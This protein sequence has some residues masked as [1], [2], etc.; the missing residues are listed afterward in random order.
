MLSK[1]TVLTRSQRQV[2]KY[3]SETATNGAK[4]VLGVIDGLSQGKGLASYPVIKPK[5]KIIKPIKPQ[6]GELTGDALDN[7]CG[8]VQCL[9]I[10]ISSEPTNHGFRV[11]LSSDLIVEDAVTGPDVTIYIS[12]LM[13]EE[14]VVE[15]I[16]GGCQKVQERAFSYKGERLAQRFHSTTHLP[17]VHEVPNVLANLV[18][19]PAKNESEKVVSVLKE[20]FQLSRQ[21]ARR[22]VWKFSGRKVSA[23][24]VQDLNNLLQKKGLTTVLHMATCPTLLPR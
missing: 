18:I 10:V 3:R 11:L 19:K 2:K 9:G 4:S 8:Q 21:D 17:L 23:N 1:E 16:F 24:H 6:K 20:Y 15:A 12:P 22:L 14:E 13:T 7:I 5:S